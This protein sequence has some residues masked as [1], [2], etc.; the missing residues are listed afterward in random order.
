MFNFFFRPS[1][2]GGCHVIPCVKKAPYLYWNP[3][4][5]PRWNT[6]VFHHPFRR[7]P[8]GWKFLRPCVQEMLRRWA[9]AQQGAAR[10]R[11]RWMGWSQPF[12]RRKSMGV[13]PLSVGEAKEEPH[14]K[15]SEIWIFYLYIYILILIL[16]FGTWSIFSRLGAN[17]LSSLK[18]QS[19]G[20]QRAMEEMGITS[21]LQESWRHAGVNLYRCCILHI[22]R[23]IISIM[24]KSE[25]KSEDHGVRFCPRQFQSMKQYQKH[26]DIQYMLTVDVCLCADNMTR[27]CGLRF[28]PCPKPAVPL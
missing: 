5:F 28:I 4:K 7:P 22:D 16:C 27:Y 15:S 25:D 3:C 8:R 26:I 23:S 2:L 9:D 11:C 19:L 6:M 18:Q 17:H 10:G 12:L 21:K 24:G 20:I 13:K 14:W 1:W